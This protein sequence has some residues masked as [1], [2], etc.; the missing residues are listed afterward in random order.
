V[1]SGSASLAWGDA[2][3]TVWSGEHTSCASGCAFDIEVPR[4]GG[5]LVLRADRA[6]VTGMDD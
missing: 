2:G 6:V 5:R 4:A 1:D 3:D